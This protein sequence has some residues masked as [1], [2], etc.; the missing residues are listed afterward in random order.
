MDRPM[1]DYYICASQS[2]Y[3]SQNSH[4]VQS[5]SLKFTELLNRGCRYIE[6]DI[7]V[8]INC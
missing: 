6:L 3:K 4:K 1:A 5:I 8:I 2:L 7:F